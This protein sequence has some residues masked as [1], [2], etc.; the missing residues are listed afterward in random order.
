MSSSHCTST[1]VPG[2]RSGGRGPEHA[3]VSAE[4]YASR[5]GTTTLE[6]TPG[7]KW[8]DEQKLFERRTS[9]LDDDEA[10]EVWRRTSQRY[11]QEASGD[12]RAF[13]RDPNPT[14]VWQTVELPALREGVE[15]GRVTR[16]E[17]IDLAARTRTVVRP[18]NVSHTSPLGGT[19]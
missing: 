4:A 9:P 16:I 1:R 17:I 6:Q 10:I 19:P 3:R 2:G 8:L 12:V 13:V 14:G 11:A 18:G 15:T 5:T 7:G